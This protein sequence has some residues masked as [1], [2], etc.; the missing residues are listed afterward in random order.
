MPLLDLEQLKR[1]NA[2]PPETCAECGAAVRKN[3]CRR[4]DE[5]FTAGHLGHCPRLKDGGVEGEG[6]E[7]HRTY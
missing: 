2:H 5:F 3:Y 1:L 6:H 4:C 7:G